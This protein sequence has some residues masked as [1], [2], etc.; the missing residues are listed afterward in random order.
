MIKRASIAA[1]LATPLLEIFLGAAEPA[2]GG[3]AA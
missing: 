3:P 2:D 1:F